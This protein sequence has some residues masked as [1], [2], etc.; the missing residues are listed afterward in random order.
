MHWRNI[1]LA[2]NSGM[3]K[4]LD[5]TL[6]L[7]I[8]TVSVQVLALVVI[9]YETRVLGP[10][11]YGKVG[12]AQ[13][14]MAYVQLIMDF[15]FILSATE[16]IANNR[17]DTQYVSR[18][19]CSV[20][21]IRL[22][23][24]VALA[25]ALGS[26]FLANDTTRHDWL[27][28]TLFLAAYIVNA[29]M[30]DYLYRGMEDMRAITFR[31][32]AVRTLFTVAVLLFVKGPEDLVLIPIIQLVG[33]ALALAIMLRDSRKRYGIRYQKSSAGFLFNLAKQSAPFFGSRIA[34]TFYQGFSTI[35]LSAVYGT[36]PIIGFY[37]SADKV[38]SVIKTGTSP[39]ADS[40]YPYMVT[41]KD[42][43]LI[44]RVLLFSFPIIAVGVCI[45]GLY[46]N[47]LC[48]FVFGA[49]YEA[50]GD[51]LR[52][53]L[54]AALVIFPSYVICFPVLVPLGLSRIA[55]FSNW[56]GV[57]VHVIQ[58]AIL[59]VT[60][61]LNVYTLCIAISITEVS[62]FFVRFIAAVIGIR[63]LK[64]KLQSAAF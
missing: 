3:R 42:Y 63:K 43:R 36:S 19:V 34:G 35:V 37:S 4:L 27:F 25:I 26:I 21:E 11:V 12:L 41:N 38:L 55:N 22:L 24:G 51:I 7:T 49:E 29:F 60:S 61:S 58:L 46:A 2:K 33:N 40:L 15:G 16:R 45:V 6:M 39:I 28:F 56:A 57:F 14:I 30:P 17:N 53:L 20:T 8:M 54:P 47:P 50:V 23:L 18:I 5:N 64:R 48:S 31:T 44:K 9:P 10:E 59:F 52:C 32:L 1:L 13:A 62:I